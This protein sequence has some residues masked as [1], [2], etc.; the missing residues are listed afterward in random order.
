[1][2][3]TLVL[4]YSRIFSLFTLLSPF[5]ITSSLHPDTP[6]LTKWFVVDSSVAFQRALH[7]VG[8]FLFYS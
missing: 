1:M 6:V 3:D 5:I 2:I 4:F 7:S 8:I